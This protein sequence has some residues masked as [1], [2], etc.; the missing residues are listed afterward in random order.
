MPLRAYYKRTSLDENAAKRGAG[1]LFTAAFTQ[2]GQSLPSLRL[3]IRRSI[4]RHSSVCRFR[5]N[6]EPRGD[7][8]SAPQ[9]GSTCSG[10]RV[11]RVRRPLT[12][13]TYHT[14]H[15]IPPSLWGA[16]T[17]RAARFRPAVTAAARIV[18]AAPPPGSQAPDVSRA[19]SPTRASQPS[20]AGERV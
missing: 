18:A 12:Q 20:P 14:C 8:C 13:A 5:I 6:A 15:P 19:P 11:S 1:P 2:K 17:A 3:C 10:Y 4:I 16:R 9:R 7:A